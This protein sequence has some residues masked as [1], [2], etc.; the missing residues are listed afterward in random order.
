MNKTISILS[1]KGFGFLENYFN[2]NA[3]PDVN[4]FI[5]D[6]GQQEWRKLSHLVEYKTL[7]NIGCAG[8]WNLIC[9]I[10]FESKNLEKI[11]I[12]NDDN[13]Y[14]IDIINE[15]YNMCSEDNIAGTYDG[16]YEFSLFCIHKNTFKNVGMFDENCLFVGAE[17]KDYKHR[18]KLNNVNISSLNISKNGNFNLSSSQLTADIIKENNEYLK[19]KWGESFEYKKPFDRDNYKLLPSKRI[20]DIY[21]DYVGLGRPMKKFPSYY[22]Y[23]IYKELNDK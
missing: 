4:I 16:G 11:V 9:N 8:G 7:R 3:F 19:L 5:I 17:V 21:G 22:E 12:S 20:L 10:A 18:C 13:I 23:D 1:Y 2:E 14:N 15:L 6:N